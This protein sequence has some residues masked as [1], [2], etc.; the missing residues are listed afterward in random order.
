MGTQW[1]GA[2]G[3]GTARTYAAPVT[4]PGTFVRVGLRPLWRQS[5]DSGLI[6]PRTPPLA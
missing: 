2:V 3:V 4:A 5:K 6:S 1:D